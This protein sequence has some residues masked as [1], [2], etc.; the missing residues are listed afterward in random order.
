MGHIV[1]PNKDYQKLQQKL[2]RTI[3]GAPNSP[4]FI[5]LLK[6]LFKPQDAKI[7]HQLPT[8][9]ATIGSLSQKTGIPQPELEDIMTDMARSS[10]S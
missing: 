5:K 7:A 2:D 4:V 9:F 8:K 10:C 1:N 6:L 3:T